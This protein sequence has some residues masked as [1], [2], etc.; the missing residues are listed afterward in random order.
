MAF[1]VTIK[2]FEYEFEISYVKLHI[3]RER[4]TKVKDSTYFTYL[5]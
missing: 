1:F 2:K 4:K 3:T 5:P